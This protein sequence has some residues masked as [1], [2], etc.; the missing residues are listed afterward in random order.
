MSQEMYFVTQISACSLCPSLSRCI[1]AVCFANLSGGS[2]LLRCSLHG[3]TGSTNPGLLVMQLQ[4]EIRL[5]LGTDLVLYVK[6]SVCVSSY[7]TE[8]SDVDSSAVVGGFG[9]S[10]YHIISTTTSKAP[11]I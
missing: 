10:D 9:L 1:S 6:V 2:S 7:R 5:L 8:S 11:Y 4:R 3:L